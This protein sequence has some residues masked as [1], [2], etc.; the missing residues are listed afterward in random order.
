MARINELVLIKNAAL[1]YSF[2]LHNLY[3]IGVVNLGESDTEAFAPFVG[4]LRC[5]C[6]DPPSKSC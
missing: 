5:S 4:G 3:L 6:M 2:N 1:L